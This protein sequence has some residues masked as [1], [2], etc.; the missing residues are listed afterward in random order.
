M[1]SSDLQT[2]G[3]VQR[4]TD[5]RPI[6]ERDRHQAHLRGGQTPGPSQ[7]RIPLSND[8]DV[9]NC[10]EPQ[11]SFPEMRTKIRLEI[12]SRWSGLHHAPE[13]SSRQPGLFRDIQR[14]IPSRGVF[15][16]PVEEPTPP[17]PSARG[18]SLWETTFYLEPR[19][20]MPDWIYTYL[21]LSH[22]AVRWLSTT[23]GVPR[24][25]L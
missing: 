13:L 1:C 19:Q 25:R 12:R 15:S 9:V 22:Q 21:P 5:T 14:Q 20:K 7:R 6:L 10:Y 2:P 4:R 3:P 18:T 17:P 16:E 11:R 8:R 23:A 24:T